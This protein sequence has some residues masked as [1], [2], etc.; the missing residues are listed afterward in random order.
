MTKSFNTEQKRSS[1]FELVPFEIFVAISYNCKNVELKQFALTCRHWKLTTNAL[2]FSSISLEENYQLNDLI[3]TMN[4]NRKMG[5]S[6]KSLNVVQIEDDQES[7]NMIAFLLGNSIETIYIRRVNAVYERLYDLIKAGGFSKLKKIH[8]P[9]N[10]TQ[11]ELYLKCVDIQR[12][13]LSEIILP[14]GETYG[15]L[16][17]KLDSFPKLNHIK[18][19]FFD[20]VPN[21]VMDIIETITQK[22][23]YHRREFSS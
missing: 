12:H 23:A 17:D 2:L 9:K 3:I 1:Y 13:C 5:I 15:S 8:K 6:V 11:N 16:Y 14:G 10:K 19:E 4:E 21:S 20:S 22:I 7:L 18:I